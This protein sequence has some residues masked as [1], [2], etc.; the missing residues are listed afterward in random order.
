MNKVVIVLSVS[1][2]VAVLA[3]FLLYS[4]GYSGKLLFLIFSSTFGL[5]VLVF[6]ITLEYIILRDAFF[7]RD[8]ISSYLQSG[9]P[10]NTTSGFN[11]QVS[12]KIHRDFT[13]LQQRHKKEIDRLNKRA[14]FRTQ[15]IADISHELKTPI[16]AAQGYVHTLL[17]GALDDEEVRYKFLKKSANSLDMLD[18]LVKDLLEL[19]QIETGNIVLMYDH[20]DVVKLVDEVLDDF[21]HN[22][23]KVSVSLKRTKQP[24]EAI[25]YADYMRIR[26]VLQN[27]VSNAVKYNHQGGKVRVKLIDQPETV[28]IQVADTGIGIPEED[29]PKVFN[30]FYRV[31]KSRTKLKKRTSSG[32]GLA[33]V[34]HLLESHQSSIM[35]KSKIGKGSVFSFTLQKDKVHE[36]AGK[37]NELDII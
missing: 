16:F 18:K 6:W 19:S 12:K 22:A 10:V 14:E 5:N 17:D 37:P 9:K 26:Q 8:N 24:T 15:F 3:T 13:L 34:K 25:V 2:L 28:E 27:L 21:E 4:A 31:D 32:L 36:Q 35:L 7:L 33:I 1:L 30:R 23:R 11:L 20:F 29:L